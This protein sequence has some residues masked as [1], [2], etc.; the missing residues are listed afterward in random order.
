[1]PAPTK[2]DHAHAR[3]LLFSVLIVATC[4]LIY[5]LITA[6]MASYLLGDSVTQFSLV[7]GVYL[8]A[9]G[10]GSWLSKYVTRRL[11]DRFIDVQLVIAVVGGCSAAAMFFGYGHLSS[12][13][14]L[15][16]SILV[17][18]GTMVGLEIPLLMRIMKDGQQL[19]DLVARVLAFDY[20]GSLLASL[21]FPLLLLPYLGL[22][23]ASFLFGTLNAGVA[24]A[25]AR[26]FQG[27]LARPRL[28]LARALLVFVALASLLILGDR[29]ER[30]A[31]ND[32][33]EDPVLIS[34]KS[35]YQR[36]TITRFGEDMRL[37]I[38]GNL[39]FSSVDEH[40]YH[41]SLIHPAVADFGA[42]RRVLVLG[43]GDGLAARELL[44]HASIE[45]VDLVDLDPA[46]TTLF[47]E[48]TLLTPLSGGSL[49]DPRLTVHNADAMR[50]VEEHRARGGDPY[51]VIVID[52]PDPNNLSL[53]KLYSRTFY[54]LV[55]GALAPGGTAV[56][57][58][59]SP[60]LA[61]RSYWCVVNTLEDAGLNPRPYHAHVPSFGDWGFVLA[62]V[63]RRPPPRR[64]PEG[65]A[66]RFL[67]DEVLASLFVFPADQ[68]R[69]DVEVNLL[70][71]QI[72]VHYYEE[73]FDAI[74]P[75][76]RR[77]G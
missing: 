51:D 73:D 61:P 42:P 17:V 26:V 4:G 64:V 8:S 12:V 71:N 62:S 33:Y 24:L 14:P 3:L 23:R 19:K 1:M 41:E 31:E 58:A 29:L 49:S 13:R 48:H 47:R 37:Y 7:I 28:L 46:M 36:L 25:C 69:L 70:N 21:L 57:Q 35:A 40:R 72:L 74:S 20:I 22:V 53:G 43:G 6:T 39:Q 55:A 5:E 65:V 67:T 50:W 10:L 11:H 60:Y 9:M 16:F 75:L 66:L 68:E 30:F 52:L 38:N 45:R 54:R 56:I 34:Q 2:S 77:N 27:Q 44:K 63:D 59:T 76:R 18:V 32:L 15:L